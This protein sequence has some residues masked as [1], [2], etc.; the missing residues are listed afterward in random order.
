M[1]VM[2]VANSLLLL[3]QF[4]QTNPLPELRIPTKEKDRLVYLGSPGG[5][6]GWIS[7]EGIA[8]QPTLPISHSSTKFDKAAACFQELQLW[9]QLFTETF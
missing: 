3:S 7:R 1:A 2:I 9:L 5:K 6:A 4:H 8:C